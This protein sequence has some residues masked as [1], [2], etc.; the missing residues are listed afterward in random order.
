MPAARLGY[1]VAPSV[2]LY[3]KAGYSNARYGEYDEPGGWHARDHDGYRVGGG[4]EYDI[5]GRF[6]VNAEYRYSHYTRDIHQ[7]QILAG[8]GVRF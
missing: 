3:A 2:M 8:V 5:L 4:A 7:N 1:V 6:Y